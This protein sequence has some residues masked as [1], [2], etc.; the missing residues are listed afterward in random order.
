M[1]LLLLAMKELEHTRETTHLPVTT[2][3]VTIGDISFV[4]DFVY[5]S[6]STS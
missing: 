1:L 5:L 3:A 6:T 4:Y 2:V